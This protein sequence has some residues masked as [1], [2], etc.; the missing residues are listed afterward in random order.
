MHALN[1]ALL[2]TIAELAIRQLGDSSEI[3]W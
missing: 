3:A 1:K 2:P